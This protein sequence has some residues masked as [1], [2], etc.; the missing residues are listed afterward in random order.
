MTEEYKKALYDAFLKDT[1]VKYESITDEQW[2]SMHNTMTGAAIAI[3]QALQPIIKAVGDAL[4]PIL[5]LL[6]GLPKD[7]K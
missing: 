6:A 4:K 5:E 3:T 1:P 7:K 2:Q